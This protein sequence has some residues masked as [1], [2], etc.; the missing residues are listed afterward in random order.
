MKNP[1]AVMLKNS[2]DLSTTLRQSVDRTLR[3][4][5]QAKAERFCFFPLFEEAGECSY[6][7]PH[8]SDR[9]SMFIYTSLPHHVNK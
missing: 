1:I 8:R 4:L 5:R 7:I 3:A 6:G 9:A 2:P